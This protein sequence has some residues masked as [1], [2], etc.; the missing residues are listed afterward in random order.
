MKRGGVI[1]YRVSYWKLGHTWSNKLR[2]TCM[3]V[4]NKIMTY[5]EPPTDQWREQ[6]KKLG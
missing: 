6:K 1:E 3:C 2:I 5:D 4:D